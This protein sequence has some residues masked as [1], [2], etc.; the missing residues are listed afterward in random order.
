MTVNP[1]SISFTIQAGAQNIPA[2][3]TIAIT[4]TTSAVL[5]YTAT[6][7]TQSGANWLVLKGVSGGSTPGSLT[8]GLVNF[9]NLAVGPYKGFVTIN[10]QASNSPVVVQVN[11]TV[12]PAATLTVSPGLFT[13]TQFGSNG[14]TITRQTIVVSSSPQVNFKATPPTQSGGPWLSID[15]STANGFTPAQVTAIVN[16][17]GLAAGTYTGTITITPSNGAAAQTVT[18]TLDVL[19][20]AVIVAYPSPMSF[21]YQQGD[22]APASQMLSLASTGTPLHLSIAATTLSGAGWLT[23]S[24]TTITTPSNVTVTIDP[25]GSNRLPTREHSP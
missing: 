3:Q 22:P 4:S 9:T 20:P 14:Q 10:S 18:I 5:N 2:D 1:A 6:V 15:P 11:L 17:A 24:P 16:A 13:V 12:I 7:S 19:A 23:A 8:V 21:T 25:T